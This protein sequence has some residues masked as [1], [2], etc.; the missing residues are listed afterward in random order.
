MWWPVVV[1][2]YETRGTASNSAPR[3]YG[4]GKRLRQCC[5]CTPIILAYR[6]RKCWLQL[7]YD[8]INTSSPCTLLIL[9]LRL[10]QRS[11]N[12]GASRVQ[13]QKRRFPCS[14]GISSL[15]VNFYT[16]SFHHIRTHLCRCG[17]VILPTL[18][19]GFVN[20]RWWGKTAPL[21]PFSSPK[22]TCVEREI[23]LL[24]RNSVA[25]LLRF[26]G[27]PCCTNASLMC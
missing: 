2:V 21:S 15:L 17:T 20:S 5:S 8:L 6:C 7:M 3:L 27:I 9:T 16:L 23:L 19:L 13:F 24:H 18:Y 12:L 10:I 22:M 1:G 26:C 11:Q 14:W 25:F 4:S